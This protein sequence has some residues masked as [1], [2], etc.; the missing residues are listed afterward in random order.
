MK[1]PEDIKKEAQLILR[2]INRTESVYDRA[3]E[4]FFQEAKIKK[5]LKDKFRLVLEQEKLKSCL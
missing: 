1:I 2:G 5:R 3:I 4:I